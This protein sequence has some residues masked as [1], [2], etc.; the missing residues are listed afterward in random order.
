MCMRPASGTGM[1][2][3]MPGHPGPVGTETQGVG[4]VGPT[5]RSST[6]STQ[7]TPTAHPQ[8]A[9]GWCRSIFAVWTVFDYGRAY[10]SPPVGPIAHDHGDVVIWL[11]MSAEERLR[12]TTQLL[13]A[14]KSIMGRVVLEEITEYEITR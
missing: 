9:L 11:T 10:I 3:S 8:E 14:G 1:P 6:L 13:S 5:C 7:V 12:Q 4:P 2:G